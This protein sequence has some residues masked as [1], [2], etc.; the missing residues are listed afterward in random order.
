MSTPKVMK[1][2]DPHTGR[3]VCR[4]CAAEHYANIK[5]GRSGCSIGALGSA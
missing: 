4:V 2:V 1:L 3:M 5:P